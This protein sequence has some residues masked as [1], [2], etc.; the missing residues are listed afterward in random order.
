MTGWRPARRRRAGEHGEE[1]Q[2]CRQVV[3]RPDERSR[4]KLALGDRFVGYRLQ[5]VRYSTINGVLSLDAKTIQ[6]LSCSDGATPVC[7]FRGGMRPRMRRKLFVHIGLPKT[8]STTIQLTL[9]CLERQLS[10]LGVH[11]PLEGRRPSGLANHRRLAPGSKGSLDERWRRL[12]A[13][14]ES[15]PASTFVLSSEYFAL[16]SHRLKCATGFAE[17]GNA[18]GI[19]VHVVAYVR[20]Q[21]YRLESEFSESAKN[22]YLREGWSDFVARKLDGGM[23]DYNRVFQSWHDV[24]GDAVVITPLERSR[25][26]EGLLAHFLGLVLGSAKVPQSLLDQAPRAPANQRLGAKLVE[27]HRLTRLGLDE[28]GR[29]WRHALFINLRHALGPVLHDDAPFAG[30][31]N[32]DLE[33]ITERFQASNARFAR[34]YAIDVG[35]V[36]FRDP[37]TDGCVDRPNCVQWRDLTE[38]EQSRVCGCVRD[39]AGIDIAIVAARNR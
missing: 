30:F 39:V 23:L 17:L 22:G 8:G 11:V 9:G 37:P 10:D 4:H 38:T 25:M 27:V 35:G 16:R 13:E 6:K 18:A 14:I 33:A 15:H 31:G 19:D 1:V 3:V 20:P 32:R 36:L 21:A 26:P 29:P 34:T 2:R 12:Q 28:G 7:A 5:V 24:F